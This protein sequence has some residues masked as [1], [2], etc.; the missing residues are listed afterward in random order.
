LIGDTWRQIAGFAP[1][2]NLLVLGATLQRESNQERE[3]GLLEP[4][5]EAG[6]QVIGE[7]PLAIGAQQ[8]ASALRQPGSTAARLGG[9]VA[10]SFVPTAVSDVAQAIDQTGREARTLPARVAARVPG[11]R[12]TLPEDADVLGQPRQAPG[13][14]GAIADPTRATTDV[15]QQNPVLAE[16]LRL[17]YGVSGFR[18]DM[19]ESDD[20]YRRRVQDFGRL[21]QSFG[22][23]LVSSPRYRSVTDEDRRFLFKTL[24]DRSK[25]L[26]DEGQLN[27][28]Q[29]LLNPA[30][31][32]AALLKR[33]GRQEAERRKTGRR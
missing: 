16:L 6:A 14:V 21:Y 24:N 10:G 15:A 17:D 18:K 23:Q 13:P 8:I 9:G 20:D 19:G 12:G 31:L 1:L 22:A 7:Q 3:G 26:V 11:L 32:F 5:A 29:S 25:Q 27:R 2:S 4:I 28:A 30:S 33:R